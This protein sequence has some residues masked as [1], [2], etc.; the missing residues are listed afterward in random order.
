MRGLKIAA[1]ASVV[2]SLAFPNGLFENDSAVVNNNVTPEASKTSKTNVKDNHLKTELVFT[3]VFEPQIES[4]DVSPVSEESNGYYDINLDENWDAYESRILASLGID[5]DSEP[6]PEIDFSVR[7]IKDMEE[8][9]NPEIILAGTEDEPIAIGVINDPQHQTRLLQDAGDFKPR[10]DVPYT[11]E[12]FECLAG[13]IALAE[14]TNY[15]RIEE[16]GYNRLTMVFEKSQSVLNVWSA[17][18]EGYDSSPAV[19]LS[20]HTSFSDP[21]SATLTSST[22]NDDLENGDV[23]VRGHY[24]L[25]DENTVKKF[26]NEYV[27]KYDSDKDFVAY[28]RF[29]AEFAGLFNSM[30]RCYEDAGFE[31]VE[32]FEGTYSDLSVNQ[33]LLSPGN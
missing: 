15:S 31:I 24:I 32:K 25:V 16:P 11:I 30:G 8:S 18:N 6:E 22:T 5:D 21:V 17:Q 13:T 29:N 19:V 33:L 9:G 4:V 28:S 14:A 1:A 12:V 7:A 26:A 3:T 27:D 23:F 2:M 20:G 10:D